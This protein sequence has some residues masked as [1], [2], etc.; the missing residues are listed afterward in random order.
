MRIIA[1]LAVFLRQPKDAAW[2]LDQRAAVAVPRHCD[3]RTKG[4]QPNIESLKFSEFGVFTKTLFLLIKSR[5][6]FTGKR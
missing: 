6:K 5:E 1:D 3:R 2:G 4:D